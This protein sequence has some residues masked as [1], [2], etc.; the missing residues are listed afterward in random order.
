[1][2]SY[3]CLNGITFVALQSTP[4]SQLALQQEHSFLRRFVA[5]VLW[6]KKL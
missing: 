4:E 5:L 1:M 3:G 2:Q 6:K